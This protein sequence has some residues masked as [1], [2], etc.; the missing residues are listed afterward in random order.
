MQAYSNARNANAITVLLG[1]SGSE[2][3]CLCRCKW[4][5]RELKTIR[6][7]LTDIIV[8]RK[9]LKAS[10]GGRE[11]SRW[12]DAELLRLSGAP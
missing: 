3:L 9:A 11:A 6:R 12:K 10:Y 7:F 1:D 2:I 5:W 4:N 8:E